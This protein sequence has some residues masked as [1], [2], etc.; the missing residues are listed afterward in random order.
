M[1]VSVCMSVPNE[2]DLKNKNNLKNEDDLKNEDNL[3]NEDDLKNEDNLKSWPLP[4]NY[5]DDFS[6]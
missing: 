2:D 1:C 3:K 4:Q 5:F 6:P